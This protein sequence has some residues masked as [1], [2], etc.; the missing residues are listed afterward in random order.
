MIRQ[1]VVKNRFIHNGNQNVKCKQCDSQFVRNLNNKVIGE[2]TK[3]LIDKLLLEK[4][5]LTGIARITLCVREMVVGL[6]QQVA[7]SISKN[8]EV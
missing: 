6:N 7:S 4:Q 5:P 3:G 2:E 8:V 1:R